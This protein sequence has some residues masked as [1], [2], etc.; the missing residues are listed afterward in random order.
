MAPWPLLSSSDKLSGSHPVAYACMQMESWSQKSSPR[1]A[2]SPGENAGARSSLKEP[3]MEIEHET[4][5]NLV[6]EGMEWDLTTTSRVA[7]PVCWCCQCIQFTQCAV[8]PLRLPIRRLIAAPFQWRSACSSPNYDT[9][10]AGSCRRKQRK[11]RSELASSPPFPAHAL[12]GGEM[13]KP[14]DR[15]GPPVA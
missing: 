6:L 11:D 13:G 9:A 4:Q 14:M 3:G 7:Q 1:P 12:Q 10:G 5:K 15:A 2:A 8:M